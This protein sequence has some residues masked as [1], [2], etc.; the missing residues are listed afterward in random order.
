MSSVASQDERSGAKCL[1]CRMPGRLCICGLS[2][3][4]RLETR[5]EAVVHYADLRR[6]SNSGRLISLALANSAVHVRGLNGQ[7]VEIMTDGPWTD[8]TLFPGAGAEELTP[9]L[10]GRLNRPLRLLVPDG[11]WNQAAGASRREP[12]LA[13]A[14]KVRLPGGITAKYRIR[15]HDD[16]TKL[17]TMEAVIRALGLIESPEAEARLEAF[18]QSWVCRT[19]YIKGRIAKAGM[20][21]GT[22]IPKQDTIL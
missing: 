5:V 9:G 20:P 1:E 11:N 6:M 15:R 17:C 12:S 16:T 14:P 13:R 8:L 19:L 7:P 3:H 10:L 18:F 2:P 21:A 22:F 4:L